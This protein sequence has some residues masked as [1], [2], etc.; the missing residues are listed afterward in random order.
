MNKE[1]RERLSAVE[2]TIDNAIEQIQEL[3]DEEQAA[4]DN[5]P[6]SLMDSELEKTMEDAIDDMEELVGQLE[7]VSKDIDRIAGL[8]KPQTKPVS[9]IIKL[10]PCNRI[11][12]DKE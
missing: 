8:D 6:E 1:R 12:H 4:H 2:F 10:E 3:I 11:R 5:L 7:V 9:K